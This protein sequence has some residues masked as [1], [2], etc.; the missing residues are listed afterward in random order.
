MTVISLFQ[1]NQRSSAGHGYPGL[2]CGGDFRA[3][4]S[5][6]IGTNG[7]TAHFQPIVSLNK[8][9]VFGYEALCRAKGE[10]PFGTIDHLFEQAQR[11]GLT[12]DLD[13]LCRRNGIE[14]AAELHIQ[15]TGCPLFLNI[16][17]N[18]LQHPEYST[19]TTEQFAH[20]AGLVKGM[21]VLEITE[22]DAVSNY[23]LFEKVIRHYRRSGFRIAID[24]FGAGYGGLKMLSI[25]EPDF[26][27][28]D[29]HFFQKREKSKVNYN[30][31]D[32]IA[33]ACHRIGV[34]VIA[35]GIEDQEDVRTCVSVG[36]DLLQGY[37]FARPTP[38]LASCDVG[39]VAGTL[40]P[41]GPATTVFN[42]VVCIGDIA[43]S[44]QPAL[45][46]ER[47]LDVLKRFS[48]H[49]EILCLPVLENGQLC[50]LVNRHRFMENHM[51]GRFGYGLNLNYYKK[52]A[53]VME[54]D[55]LQVADYLSVEEVS[56][57]VH[58]RR[59]ET[60]YDDICVT[61]S[62]RYI[63]MVSVG[64]VLNAVTENSMNSARGANPLTGLPGNEAIQRKIVSLLSK[65]IH[66]DVCYVD[67]D[68]FKPFNDY[69]G[70]EKGDR[71]IK[72]TA[73]IINECLAAGEASEIGFA[74]HIGGD[75]FILITRPKNSLAICQAIIDHFEQLRST[76]HTE[77]TCRLGYYL[78]ED[79]DG[80]KRRFGLLSL[81]IG[82]VS[83]EM[84]PMVSFA[85]I[86]SIAGDLKKI[87]KAQP[88]SAVVR[89]RRAP[90]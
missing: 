51:V 68:S 82:V 56:R 53:D 65:S 61:R 15:Q 25:L 77:D 31:I 10:N 29:R 38:M 40:L 85:E 27:K 34:E 74:G 59:I 5:N 71:V 73:A 75:D 76:F 33:T 69:H 52:V 44:V 30:L 80:F 7:L 50:G 24:D 43:V 42:E 32:A 19:G 81:S 37:Y 17:P 3:V 47:A 11:H 13:M 55:L 36:I 86:A 67:I 78:G 48:D 90:A 87:A 23:Q 89:D 63:G 58:E 39:I 1:E 8:R 49:P 66:F 22:R 28:I 2:D 45:A 6:L 14:G 46:E 88:G 83:T 18:S 60:T 9:E 54:K 12:L 16:C 41:S 70:F 26:V 35:E 64:E 84:Y 4:L 62:G 57:K 20:R 21:I 72:A 79:R